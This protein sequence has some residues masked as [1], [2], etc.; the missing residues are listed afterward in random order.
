MREKA[1]IIFG[2][3]AVACALATPCAAA[4]LLD[5]TPRAHL[6]TWTKV[7]DTKSAMADSRPALWRQHLR[8][9]TVPRWIGN[10][11]IAV[12]ALVVFGST[13]DVGMD[14]SSSGAS[15]RASNTAFEEATL[16]ETVTPWIVCLISQGSNDGQC[17]GA[18]SLALDAAV[19]ATACGST[20]ALRAELAILSHAA[21]EFASSL[22]SGFQTPYAT[23]GGGPN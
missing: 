1:P 7:E 2:S 17:D 19:L 8:D 20:D 22:A 4:T 9:G 12:E 10:R 6:L 5:V 14:Y 3:L 21:G 23:P 13:S 16:S 15:G 11:A 18:A